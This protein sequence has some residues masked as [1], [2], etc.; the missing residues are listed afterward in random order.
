MREYL[1]LERMK[2]INKLTLDMKRIFLPHR[3][4]IREE[5]EY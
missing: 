5:S 4:V 1:D 3:A 2:R